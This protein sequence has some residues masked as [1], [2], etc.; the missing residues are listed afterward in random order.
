MHARMPLV[1]PH[2]KTTSVFTT[3]SVSLWVFVFFHL[4]KA[5][6]RIFYRYL[7]HAFPLASQFVHVGQQLLPMALN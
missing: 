1:A 7:E 5:R 6:G 4:L 2:G 3:F